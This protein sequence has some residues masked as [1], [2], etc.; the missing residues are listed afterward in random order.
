MSRVALVTE[1]IG[2]GDGGFYVGDPDIPEGLTCLDWRQRRAQA[3]R[4]ERREWPRP[5]FKWPAFHP[6][7][8]RR[9]KIQPGTAFPAPAFGEKP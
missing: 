9:P 4:G 7:S 2:R 1:Y 8:I 6:P 3:R 5:S